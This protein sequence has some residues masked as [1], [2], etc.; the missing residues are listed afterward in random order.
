MM[1]KIDRDGG[2][3]LTAHPVT[4]PEGQTIPAGVHRVLLVS[5][6]SIARVYACHF[7]IAS[8]DVFVSHQKN[9]INILALPT[10]AESASCPLLRPS[11]AGPALHQ[12]SRPSCCLS[13]PSASCCPPAGVHFSLQV[14]CKSHTRSLHCA[15]G[16]PTQTSETLLCGRHGVLGHEQ[17]MTD[18]S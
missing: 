5:G 9:Q 18:S 2:M 8:F 3:T 11:A 6:H 7:T 17:S 10:T 13:H 14:A 4:D 15:A 16:N 12:L 1:K